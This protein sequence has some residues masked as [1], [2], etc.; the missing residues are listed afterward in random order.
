MLLAVENV[1]YSYPSVLNR[2]LVFKPL[3][4]TLRPGELL[5]LSGRNGAGK[6]TLLKILSGELTPT[7]GRV[8]TAEG[9]T[10]IYLNQTITDF[11]AEGL[12]VREQFRLVNDRLV[13]N[14]DGRL[15]PLIVQI[16]HVLSSVGLREDSDTFLGELSGGQK[17]IVALASVLSGRFDVL[18][19]DE[20]QAH[21]DSLVRKLTWDLVGKY[22]SA[23]N[24]GIIFVDHADKIEDIPKDGIMTNVYMERA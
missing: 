17:Q 18:L 15:A 10:T 6:S 21:M 7:Q 16:Q 24:S 1:A 23:H 19:L 11:L 20:F 4:F 8:L 5:C 9:A 3:S 14:S 13:A 22:M 12:T 2:E